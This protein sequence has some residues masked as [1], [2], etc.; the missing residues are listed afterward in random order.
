LAVDYLFAGAQ[1]YEASKELLLNMPTLYAYDTERELCAGVVS[2]SKGELTDAALKT[3]TD[4]FIDAHLHANSVSLPWTGDDVP[5]FHITLKANGKRL[6]SVTC[7]E[8][9]AWIIREFWLRQS[10]E[11]E[12]SVM[13]L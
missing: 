5:L 12:I 9:Q 10:P 2:H 6:E 3:L 7:N 13:N 1:K 8:I 11:A 4:R